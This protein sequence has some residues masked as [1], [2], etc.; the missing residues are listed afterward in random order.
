MFEV[1][2]IYYDENQTKA[3]KTTTDYPDSSAPHVFGLPDTYDVIAVI[4][5]PGPGTIVYVDEEVVYNA[6]DKG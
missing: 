5:T 3:L 1:I 6:D 4:A 2:V